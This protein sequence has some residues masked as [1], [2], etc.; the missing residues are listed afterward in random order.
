MHTQNIID[1]QNLTKI[2]RR[3]QKKEGLRGSLQGLIKPV[4][5]LVGECT[6]GTALHALIVVC[7]FSGITCALWRGGIRR[8]NSASS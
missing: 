1:T 3:F 8:Y 6:L 2:Y 7:A 5:S 4:K